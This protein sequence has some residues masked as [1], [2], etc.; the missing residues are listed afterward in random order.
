MFEEKIGADIIIVCR[1]IVFLLQKNI[2]HVNLHILFQ[3]E[4]SGPYFLFY[5]FL[6]MPFKYPSQG[7]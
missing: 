6:L 2:L 1:P 3:P 5:L 7:G 4:V